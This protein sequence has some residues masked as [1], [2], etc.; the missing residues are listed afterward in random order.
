[1]KQVILLEEN[2]RDQL[3]AYSL[4]KLQKIVGYFEI[5]GILVIVQVI[6]AVTLDIFNTR[7]RSEQNNVVFNCIK[8]GRVFVKRRS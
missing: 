1:M 2:L 4:I 3:N 7:L 6:F 8:L 5:C